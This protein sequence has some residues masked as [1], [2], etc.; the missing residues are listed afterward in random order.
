MFETSRDQLGLRRPSINIKRESELREA[1][2]RAAELSLATCDA[3]ECS[4]LVLLEEWKEIQ[5]QEVRRERWMTAVSSWLEAHDDGAGN[6]TEP[7]KGTSWPSNGNDDNEQWATSEAFK[8]TEDTC[9]DPGNGNNEREGFGSERDRGSCRSAESTLSKRR[10]IDKLA[11]IA[12]IQEDSSNLQRCRIKVRSFLEDPYAS[13]WSHT[14]YIAFSVLIFL[15]VLLGIIRESDTNG[16]TLQGILDVVD[17][18]FVVVFTIEM[19][20]RI[21]CAPS[22]AVMLSMYIWM[23]I[24]AVLP[25]FITI[26]PGLHPEGNIYIELLVILVPMFRLLKF[27]RHSMGWRLIVISIKKCVQPLTIPLLLLM[28]MTLFFAG[29][30]YWIDKHFANCEEEWLLCSRT[31]SVE[32]AFHSVPHAM[33]FALTTASTVGY[34]D[35]TPSTE[36]GKLVASFLILVGVG[37]FSMPLCIIGGIFW[38]VWRER[39]VIFIRARTKERLSEGRVTVDKVREL[40]AMVDQD[41]NGFLRMM[42]FVELISAF[43]LGI[44]KRDTLR[45]FRAID[46][47]G[48]GQINFAEFT[49]FLFPEIAISE[50]IEVEQAL[51]D[52]ASGTSPLVNRNGSFLRSGTKSTDSIRILSK[53]SEDGDEYQVS[54]L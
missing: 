53:R 1:E 9:E 42:E 21:S 31:E 13:H 54:S 7:S 38:D 37:Y 32:P 20:L 48:S 8:V 51:S 27:T 22:A 30:L 3:D 44:S 40:F 36:L 17:I 28:L 52:V 23:D 39:D 33:W 47:D 41:G 35:V 26:V 49:H 2:Q 46:Y 25:S 29:I 34:G 4:W 18:V 19:V 11:G 24:L 50:E 45:L 10:T 43:K 15:S 16:S 6:F 12:H 5:I 14:W